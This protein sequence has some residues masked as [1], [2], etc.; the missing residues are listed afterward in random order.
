MPWNVLL[1]I[2]YVGSISRHL[3][4]ES[5]HNAHYYGSAWLPQNQDPTLAPST[6]GSSALPADMYRPYVGYGGG[7]MVNFGGSSNFNSLQVGAQRRMSRDLQIGVNYRWGKALGT[8]SNTT[9]A[10]YPYDLKQRE[11]GPLLYDRAHT[12]V[13]GPAGRRLPGSDASG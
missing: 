13:I 12:L 1:D 2:G 6:D 5:P 7:V 11:Y 10:V 3:P 4:M 9:E 8:T